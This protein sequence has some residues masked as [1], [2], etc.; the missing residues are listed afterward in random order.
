MLGLTTFQT[1]MAQQQ[2]RIDQL[3]ELVTQGKKDHQL[4]LRQRAELRSPQ[5]L[6]AESERLGMV[7]AQALGF[8]TVDAATYAAVLGASGR[9]TDDHG[10]GG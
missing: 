4:L 5:R 6:G 10:A 8:V 7:Q 3:Q 1:R 9:L 2:V